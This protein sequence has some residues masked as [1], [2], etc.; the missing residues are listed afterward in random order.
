MA[1]RR[2]ALLLLLLVI[3][4]LLGVAAGALGQRAAPSTVTSIL[5]V[6]STITLRE[7]LTTLLTTTAAV[8]LVRTSVATIT[9]ERPTTLTTTVTYREELPCL[10]SAL[11]FKGRVTRIVDGDTLDVDKVTVRLALVDTPER[12]APGYREATEFTARVCPV[13]SEA[14]VDVDDGQPIA[15]N[16]LIARVICG[17]VVLNEALLEEEHAVIDTRFCTVSEF[18]TQPWA[19]KHGC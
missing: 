15:T 4:F 7:T 6:T 1:G 11:C 8:E 17:G 3:G 14:I 10:G 13:G 12:G 2:A 18:S 9:L 5:E 16:R 19:E